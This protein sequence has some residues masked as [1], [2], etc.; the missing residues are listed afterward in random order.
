MSEIESLTTGKTLLLD[1]DAGIDDAHALMVALT[2]DN[3]REVVGV[4]CT[5]GNCL[6][7]QVVKNVS[8][9]LQQYDKKI[10]VYKGAQTSLMRTYENLVFHGQDGLGDI[11]HRCDDKEWI[12]SLLQSE[13][14]AIAMIN[15]SKKYEKQITLIAIGP[16]TNLALACRIDGNFPSRLKELI[17]MGGNHTALGNA[18]STGEFN[19]VVDPEAAAIVLDEFPRFCPVKVVPLEVTL[20]SSI[21]LDWISDIWLKQDSPRATLNRDM[22]KNFLN[23]MKAEKR[24]GYPAWDVLAVAAALQPNFIRDSFKNFMTVELHG[25]R[26]RGQ[27]V[28]DRKTKCDYPVE[29]I[30][31]VD[32][33]MLRQ[34]LYKSTMPAENHGSS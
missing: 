19:F 27:G 7:D 10:P 16:L 32:R 33:E 30:T 5:Y 23:K 21:E 24:E 25:S 29:I 13:H 28:I 12:D 6:V 9:I 3:C 17:I 4:T 18:T 2:H 34:M 1:T 31:K 8:Y 22:M 15:L 26:T 11:E 14:G 20:V